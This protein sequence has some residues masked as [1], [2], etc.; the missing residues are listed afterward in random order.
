MISYFFKLREIDTVPLSS[1]CV[2]SSSLA[3]ETLW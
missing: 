1:Q 2:H 3:W